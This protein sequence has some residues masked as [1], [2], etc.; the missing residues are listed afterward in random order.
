MIT[1]VDTGVKFD[2]L[3]IKRCHTQTVNEE[4]QLLSADADPPHVS[5]VN[6]HRRG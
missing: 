1:T 3:C 2:N 4:D 5:G 6:G